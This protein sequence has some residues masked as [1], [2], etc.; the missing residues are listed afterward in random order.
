MNQYYSDIKQT[1]TQQHERD[2]GEIIYLI[3]LIDIDTK[4]FNKIFANR[5]QEVTKKIIHTAK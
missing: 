3:S 1:K 5:I 4:I 2:M